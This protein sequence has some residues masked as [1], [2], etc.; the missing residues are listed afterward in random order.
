MKNNSLKSVHIT[1]YY[2]A[3]SG[4]VKTNY[5]KLLVEANKNQRYVSLIVPGEEEKTEQ[6]GEYGKIYYIAAKPSPIFDKRYRLMLPQQYIPGESVIR[7]VLMQEMP[8]MIEIYDNYSL[9]LLAGLIRRG[10]F[11]QLN[12]PMLVYFTGE[13]FDTI[14]QSFVTK[15]WFGKWFPKRLM[16]N[17]N[18][19]MFDFYIA[20][21]DF[22][23][24]EINDALCESKNQHRSE[25]FLNKCWRFF[26]GARIPY[27]KRIEI[28]PRGVDT[29]FYSPNNKSSEFRKEICEKFGFP[30][31]SVI[32][33][34]STRLSPE[35]NIQILSPIMQKLAK[36][37]K[38]DF[39]LIVA[40]AGPREEWLKEECD[41]YFPKKM[42][43]AGHLDKSTL[44]KYYAN[45][46]IFIH[47]NPR[48]PFGNVGLEAMASG[49]ACA[50]PNSGGVLTYANAENSWLVE[51]TADG[52]VNAFEQ[53]ISSN[54][55]TTRRRENA[56]K[57]AEA[58]SQSK[59]IGKLFA[60]YDRMFEDFQRN[61]ELFGN[62]NSLKNFDF[63]KLFS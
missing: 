33:M 39:R 3:V 8:D 30:E 9:T 14:F 4:G 59:A 61:P 43:L 23:A 15:N 2:H 7:K 36:N 22:V 5:D 32:L 54:E 24:E 63:A 52:Y 51:P 27:E 11:K 34:T 29:E 62:E 49:A 26:N 53:I 47:P 57:T 19:A 55:E 10:N 21:S 60:T 41:K 44:A 40:G 37:E 13:R 50:F 17:Y 48:E 45:C 58:N 25:M 6:V 16:S 20:N 35:K 38:T 46:D 18:L 12:R 1:N 56:I 31:N 28:C 42:Q